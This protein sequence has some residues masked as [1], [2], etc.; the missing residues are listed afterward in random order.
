MTA[1]VDNRH[2]AGPKR[3]LTEEDV[4]AAREVIYQQPPSEERKK[5]LKK[6]SG[7]LRQI[8]DYRKG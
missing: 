4:L 1:K 6:I 7:Q 2:R 8:R 3:A 5:A